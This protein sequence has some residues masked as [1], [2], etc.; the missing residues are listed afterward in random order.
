MKAGRGKVDLQR[1][2]GALDRTAAEERLHSSPAVARSDR[3]L[4]GRAL[5]DGIAVCSRDKHCGHRLGK[6]KTF[7]R[8][9]RDERALGKPRT[10]TH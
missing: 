3:C 9:N 7:S 2:N 5:P 4:A 10:S 1:K 8:R 6:P